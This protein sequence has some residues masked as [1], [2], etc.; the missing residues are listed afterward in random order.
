MENIIDNCLDKKDYKK[1]ISLCCGNTEDGLQPEN[2]TCQFPNLGL[3]LSS[4]YNLPYKTN[5]IK[6]KLL[7]NWTD[8]KTLVNIWKKMNNNKNILLV[9]SEPCDYYVVINDT[10]EN[11]IPDKTFLFHMEPNMPE[12]TK[13]YLKVF[14]HN[15]DYNNLEWHLSKTYKELSTQPIIKDEFFSD[16]LSTVLSSKYKDPGHQIRI[17]FIKFI[18]R[19]MTVHVYGDNKYNYN[20][21]RGSL[22]YHNKDNSIL[23]YK[24][25]FNAENNQIHNYFT[26]KIIDGI[27]GESLVFYWGCPNIEKYIDPRAFIKLKLINFEEDFETIQKAIRE[28]WWSQRLPYIKAEK[29]K[30]LND[31]QFYPRLQK[32]IRELKN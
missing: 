29:Y 18:D 7:C 23:P 31:L 28:D 16:I 22:P 3:I 32:T 9:D 11:Y 6:I 13:K 20:N 21:Y 26:E 10:S 24:Y 14:S 30:I 19:K 15:R 27:L 17:D 25:I 4:L 8:S 1:A 12:T 2:K 5:I